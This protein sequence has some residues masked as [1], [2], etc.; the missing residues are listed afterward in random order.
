MKAVWYERTGAAPD[1]LI[2]GEI[3]TPSA[4]PGEVRV[5]LEASGINPSDAKRR[6]V[7]LGYS[8]FAPESLY[9]V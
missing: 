5:R 9:R 3:P 7:L 1:V 4:G 2:F 8:G 6:A